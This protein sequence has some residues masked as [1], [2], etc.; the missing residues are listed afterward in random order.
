M[1][2][3]EKLTESHIPQML[4]LAAYAFNFPDPEAARE[5][6]EFLAQHSW[7]YGDL[8]KDTLTSQVMA[9]PFTVDFHGQEYSMAGVGFVAS[10]PEYR[11]QGGIN[12]TMSYLLADLNEQGI[13]LSYLAPF[14]YPF[15][16]RYGYELLFERIK[17]K[18]S[19]AEWPNVGK[20]PGRMRRMTY[21]GIKASLAE[22]YHAMPAHT[23]GGL[24][25]E[26]WWLDY[27]LSMKPGK[28]FAQY[29]AEDGTVEGYLVYRVDGGTFVIEEIGYLNATALK[30]ITGFI[31]SH[32]GAFAEFVYESAYTGSNLNYLLPSARFEMSIRPEMMGRIINVERFLQKYPFKTGKA[33]EFYL[34]VTDDPFAEWNEGIYCVEISAEGQAQVE[35]LTETVDR[36]V[37]EGTIQALTQLLFGYKTG[38]ELAFYERLQAEESVLERFS[39][40]LV[41]ELPVLEDYF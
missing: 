26:E 27:K 24:K 12:R 20:V 6:F 11:G 22:I 4:D 13:D 8:D 15:Y 1:N 32:S 18:L 2:K 14:S 40:Y 36:P 25:R 17:Y 16:R 19:S 38:A 9:T 28:K 31:G 39:S 35:K 29:E 34:K 21:D 5:R 7:N 33:A 23:R 3:A 41:E 10:Y 37:I 30:A